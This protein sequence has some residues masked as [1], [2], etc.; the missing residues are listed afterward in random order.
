MV[1][2][3]STY[4]LIMQTIAGKPQGAVF[5]SAAFLAAGKRTAVDQALF[6][7]MKAG[8]IM[9]VAGGLYAA[10]GQGVDA[11]TVAS[12]L[13]HKTGERVGLAPAK[14]QSDVLVVA[15]SGL[16][17]TVNHPTYWLVRA[18]LVMREMQRLLPVRYCPSAF[19]SRPKPARQNRST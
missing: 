8:T 14:M 11:R 3:I 18:A 19:Y 7:M 17:R 1:S 5:S 9:R 15:T 4:Q 10:A 6:R 2:D 16:S 12:A 13:T